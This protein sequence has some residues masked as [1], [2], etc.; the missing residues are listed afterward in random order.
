MVEIN[1]I[2]KTLRPAPSR[3]SVSSVIISDIIPLLN[4][5]RSVVHS[6][7]WWVGGVAGEERLP[8]K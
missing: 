3:Q 4:P 7:V 5:K 6:T 1:K 2:I 8:I